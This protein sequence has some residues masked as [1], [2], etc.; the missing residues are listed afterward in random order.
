M[1]ARLSGR[2][3]SWRTAGANERLQS[4]TEKHIGKRVSEVPETSIKKCNIGSWPPQQ[5]QCVGRPRYHWEPK[6]TAIST[7][8]FCPSG[9]Y[10]SCELGTQMIQTSIGVELPQGH[11]LEPYTASS[12][13]RC[14]S[15]RPYPR[16]EC[17]E[18]DQAPLRADRIFCSFTHTVAAWGRRFG[19]LKASPLLE[20][21]GSVH[22]SRKDGDVNAC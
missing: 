5:G 22:R 13:A 16:L 17:M 2:G 10:Q 15:G 14:Q 3:L 4:K 12:L 11:R 9:T 20:E 1:A 21:V 18:P 8:R 7:S 19:R 6:S